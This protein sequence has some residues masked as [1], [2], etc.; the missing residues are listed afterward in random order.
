M[1]AKASA[2][3]EAFSAWHLRSGDAALELIPPRREE[4]L[5]MPRGVETLRRLQQGLSAGLPYNVFRLCY[6]S[7]SGWRQLEHG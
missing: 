4:E 1:P 6:E 2:C 3:S 5:Q 7:G